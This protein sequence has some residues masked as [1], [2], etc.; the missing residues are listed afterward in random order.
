MTSFRRLMIFNLLEF[1][2]YHA[3]LHFAEGIA[4]RHG[5]IVNESPLPPFGE[6]H[7]GM[8]LLA[9][10]VDEPSDLTVATYNIW[11][12]M[13]HWEVRKIHIAD[14]IETH[15]I[16]VVGFQ[17]V[18]A[19]MDNSHNQ[20]HDLQERLPKYKSLLYHP[21]RVVRQKQE[22]RPPGWE[23]E[24]IGILS[25][26]RILSYHVVNLTMGTGKDR[27][28]RSVLSA[29]IVV[30]GHEISVMVTHFS[31]D[32][33]DQCEN[34]W[35]V[36]KY[37]HS[38]RAEKMI[39]LGDFNVYNEYH[40]PMELL[41]TGNMDHQAPSFCQKI[42]KPWFHG[43]PDYEFV[44]AWVEAN[45]RN[46]GFTFSNMPQP[47]LHSRPDR[48]LVSKPGFRI[49]SAFKLGRGWDYRRDY[50]NHLRLARLHAIYKSAQKQAEG[51]I[52]ESSCY[53]DC[54]PHG[55]CR[56]GIC[57]TKRDDDCDESYCSFCGPARLRY[58]QFLQFLYISALLALLFSL[59][60][61][62]SR[63]LCGNTKSAFCKKLQ[64][65]I[66]TNKYFLL[67]TALAI[68]FLYIYFK[69]TY[70]DVLQLVDA[71]IAEELYPSDHMMVVARIIFE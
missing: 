34:A 70:S 33:N 69:W 23:L 15:G 71:Q 28:Q 20:L 64:R 40:W 51:N 44:D 17:E 39:I 30:N 53:W 1:I 11:N 19:N 21:T 48:I 55:I 57:V 62:I 45:P 3:V 31:Y 35:D 65:S 18:R 43:R 47:G 52:Y 60:V 59:G 38:A 68:I 16:D 63:P 24:G 8:R 25:K 27:T 49:E 54:G 46:P 4:N 29:Q 58:F 14:M 6:R 42:Q 9:Q 10:N 66:V 2:H 50:S 5:Q 7:L 37:L 22:E 61:C 41:L 32:T 26:H 56:C 13:F 67:L 36:L 12:I